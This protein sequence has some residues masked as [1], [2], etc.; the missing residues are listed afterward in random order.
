MNNVVREISRLPFGK[1]IF[2]K[3]KDITVLQE[4]KEFLNAIVKGIRSSK[5]RICI[6]S[7]YFGTGPGSRVILDELIKAKDQNNGLD[8]RIILDHNRALRGWPNDSSAR[9]LHPLLEKS[10]VS[11]SLFQ[12]PDAFPSLLSD[13]LPYESREIFGTFR[14]KSY[15][16]DD[17]V[18]LTGADLSES[19][20]ETK[21]DRYIHVHNATVADHYEQFMNSATEFSNKYDISPGSTAKLTPIR[22]SM[23]NDECLKGLE[24]SMLR[25]LADDKPIKSHSSEDE[26]EYDTFIKHS[27]QLYEA[28]LCFDEEIFHKILQLI[29]E[30]PNSDKLEIAS[31][32]MNFTESSFGALEV[33][34]AVG[35]NIRFICGEEFDSFF[36][37][38][39]LIGTPLPLMIQ[40]FHKLFQQE[41]AD[42]K[43]IQYNRINWDFHAK[44]VW[45][46]LNGELDP[47][48]S[49]IGGSNLSKRSFRRDFDSTSWIMT[50]SD[51]LSS[52]FASERDALFHDDYT[53]SVC[54]NALCKEDSSAESEALKSNQGIDFSIG[55]GFWSRPVSKIVNYVSSLF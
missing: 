22:D 52:Q 6:S 21:Q 54:L 49:M 13:R 50:T 47:S 30:S 31:G 18:I 25:L 7:T 26:S 55:T 46:S 39:Q 29:I 4:P 16:F 36:D 35:N 51:D 5:H 40:D 19:F 1:N 23:S 2:A 11:L 10:G 20:Y 43:L 17:E 41:L 34:L 3:S 32:Y 8:I 38:A 27:C 9:M 45:W 33:A 53:S 48:L 44:G 28:G 37:A 24:E 14:H 15:V 12:M 42:L